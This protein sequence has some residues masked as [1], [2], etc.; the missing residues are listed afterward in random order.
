MSRLDEALRRSSQSPSVGQRKDATGQT[1]H[2]FASPWSLGQEGVSAPAAPD[3]TLHAERPAPTSRLLDVAAHDLGPNWKQWFLSQ[4]IDSRIT[5]QF[6]RL[7]AALLHGQREGRLKV[8]MVTSAIPGEGK[9]LTALNLAFVL[10]ESYRRRVL[11]IDADLRR[12]RLSEAANLTVSEGLGEML[13]AHEDRKAPLAQLTDRLC[14]LPAGRPD[15][16]PLSG[17]T[18][19][20]MQSLLE[21]AAEQFDWVIVD[22][23]PATVTADAGL[24]GALVDGTVLVVRAGQTPHPA[25][26]KAVE[27]L[28]QDRIFGVVLNGV[29]R[30]NEDETYA[31]GY[32]AQDTR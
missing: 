18:S 25:V 8:V 13:K 6:R 7:A 2:V 27:T 15:P 31:Y 21:E 14:L 5:E 12:P 1:S 26:R 17:L 10:A 24:I 20:R 28:G 16:E 11:L 30:G 4:D 9:T 29:A 23:P 3:D 22:T 19:R 32:P